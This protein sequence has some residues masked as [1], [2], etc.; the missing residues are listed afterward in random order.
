MGK[1]VH[2]IFED[3]DPFKDLPIDT[4]LLLQSQCRHHCCFPLLLLFHPN[5]AH[6]EEPVTG[7]EEVDLHP[8]PFT[9]IILTLLGDYHRI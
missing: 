9:S 4:K 8:T 7:V 5:L 1:K 6:F 3:L 2:E